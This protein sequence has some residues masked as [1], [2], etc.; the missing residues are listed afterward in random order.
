M[1]ALNIRMPGGGGGDTL[2]YVVQLFNDES[3]HQHCKM[4]ADKISL[5]YTL[6][7][8]RLILFGS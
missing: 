2:D 7:K 6:Q 3:I 1:L 4:V 5:L 8:E